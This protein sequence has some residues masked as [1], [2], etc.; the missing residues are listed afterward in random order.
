[1]Q[2]Q[3]L[4][5]GDPQRGVADL[6]A[7]IELGQQLIAGQLAAG[8]LGADHERV[9]L[10]RLAFVPLGAAGGTRVA[11]VL[12]IGAVV[13]EQLD[14]GLAEEVVAVVQLLGNLAAQDSCF[15]S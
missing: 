14:A 7:Q 4:A 1:M 15:R 13:L 6:V 5:A 3:P 11:V 12:L 10:G 9:G 8:N 2:L